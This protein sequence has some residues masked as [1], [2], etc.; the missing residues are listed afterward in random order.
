MT[1]P[2]KFKITI[3]AL[4]F[5]LGCPSISQDTS[6]APP[7]VEA[8]AVSIVS[9]KPTKQTRTQPLRVQFS[10]PIVKS[11]MVNQILK[12]AGPFQISPPIPGTHKW[13]SE[14]LLSYV[15][16][17]PFK[18]STRYKVTIDESALGTKLSG[19]VTYGFNTQMFAFK[20]VEPFYHG[21]KGSIKANLIFSHPVKPSDIR[22][23]VRFQTTDGQPLQAIL[24]TNKPSRTIAYDLAATRQELQ[25]TNVEVHVEGQLSALAG[26][27]SL[28]KKVVRQFN[29]DGAPQLKVNNVWISQSGDAFKV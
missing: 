5:L 28:G 25:H 11:D 10:R 9:F 14:Y 3:W 8:D 22:A 21:Q 19:D 24:Q 15:P 6:E 17:E 16:S 29:I 18:A 12:G 27:S 23:A 20:S 1:T 7:K 4:P 13:E 2:A 26:S